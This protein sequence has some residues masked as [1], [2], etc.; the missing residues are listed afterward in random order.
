MLPKILQPQL[1][2][3]SAPLSPSVGLSHLSSVFFFFMVGAAE[4]IPAA[5]PLFFSLVLAQQLVQVLPRCCCCLVWVSQQNVIPGGVPGVAFGDVGYGGIGS[6]EGFSSL[7]NSMLCPAPV[8][9]NHL[10]GLSFHVQ[11]PWELRASVWP[12]QP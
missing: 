5:F 3:G 2:A 1:L 12:L 7:K 9:G 4:S 10:R 8:A 6:A 11:H